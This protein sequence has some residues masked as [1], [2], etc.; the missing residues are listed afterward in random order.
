MG[1]R[2]GRSRGSGGEQPC[3][4]AGD[5]QGQFSKQSKVKQMTTAKQSVKGRRVDFCGVSGRLRCCLAQK[6]AVSCWCFH[7]AKQVGTV[8]AEAA[9]FPEPWAIGPAHHGPLQSLALPR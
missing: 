7:D 4:S 8:T 9:D 3:F 6:K 1:A 5:Q 2:G